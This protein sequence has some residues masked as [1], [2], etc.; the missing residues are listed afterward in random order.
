MPA[1][2][3]EAR[4]ANAADLRLDTQHIN[5]V[6]SPCLI[7]IT[8]LDQ[9]QT[10][11][12]LIGLGW[13]KGVATYGTCGIPDE[14]FPLVQAYLGAGTEEE[15]ISS[16][17]P[18]LIWLVFM[19]HVTSLQLL[20]AISRTV[21]GAGAMRA[22]FAD[23]WCRDIL[24]QY[25]PEMSA[26][27]ENA[28]PPPEEIILLSRA[29]GIEAH[30]FVIACLHGMIMNHAIN[31]DTFKDGYGTLSDLLMRWEG[32]DK[33]ITLS[34]G[35]HVQSLST[36]DQLVRDTLFQ[37]TQCWGKDLKEGGVVNRKLAK[38]LFRAMGGLVRRD[39]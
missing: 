17:M 2:L 23:G 27:K 9:G 19:Q 14:A 24:L 25:L 32:G 11:Q 28:V 18:L 31:A 5:G 37:L 3:L 6:P 39:D 35:S 29:E 15:A 13:P 26:R 16:K 1:N 33:K 30:Q 8:Y 21:S 34:R 38:Q 36:I 20:D 4:L 7:P 22:M 12:T 10:I